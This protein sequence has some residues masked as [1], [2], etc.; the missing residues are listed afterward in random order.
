MRIV[1]LVD[2]F[3]PKLGYQETFLAREH[4]KL[5]H[6]V[7]V[8]TSDR[9]YPFSNYMTA[10]YKLLGKRLVGSGT[11]I[12]EGIKTIRLYG[13]EIM[14]APLI[15]LPDLFQTLSD[16]KPDVVFCHNMYSLISASAAYLKP[17]IGYKLIYDTH[18][19]SFNTNLTDTIP[20][21]LYYFFYHLLAVS[22]IKKEKDAIFAIGEE[23]QQFI[24][25]DFNFNKKNIPII[26]L[27]VDIQRFHLS[28][29]RRNIIREKL[30]AQKNDILMIFTG[31]IHPKKDIHILL[32]ALNEIN[33]KNI[34][35]MII[36][37]G[38]NDYLKRLKKIIRDKR[39]VIWKHF[40]ANDEL[41]SYY[42]AS[43]FGTWPGNP[44]ISML[45]AMSCNLPLVLPKS[46][47]TKY[48]DKSGAI[49]WFERSNIKELAERIK[50]LSYN[51]GKSK[52]LGY[53]VRNFIKNNLSWRKIAEQ[54]LSII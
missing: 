11:R 24:C 23:E 4:A 3:Q 26:R 45:E 14:G 43:D 10:F 13:W 31:K 5:G 36:G 27:G 48:L 8:V 20:K 1:H 40:V 38:D 2:Y 21:K 16:V 28:A 33:N 32:Q 34:K 35:L 25:Q 15:Y 19:A 39:R 54:T 47:G 51:M 29:K 44:S 53:K 30:G 22:K 42:S 46:E 6:K 52:E 9:Y 50:Q 18:T 12:E 49:V 41:P 17:K 7:W 37:D